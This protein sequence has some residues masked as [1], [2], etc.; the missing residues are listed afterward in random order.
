MSIGLLSRFTEENASKGRSHP[1]SIRDWNLNSFAEKFEFIYRKPLTVPRDKELLQYLCE[2]GFL[3]AI[4][5]GMCGPC[6]FEVDLSYWDEHMN[7]MRNFPIDK[8]RVKPE[9]YNITE[10]IYFFTTFI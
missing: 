8:S 9:P 1:A 2:L 3:R 5:A 7:E 4:P 10:E 6:R